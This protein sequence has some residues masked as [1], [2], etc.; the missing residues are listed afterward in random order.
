MR[1]KL[2]LILLFIISFAASA[3]WYDFIGNLQFDPATP[4]PPH[5]E[6]MMFYDNGAHAV[7]Y[8]NDEPD[9]TLNVGQ[10]NFI[11]VRNVTGSTITDGSAVIVSGSTG[12]TPQIS[13]A[14]ADLIETTLIIGLA[15]HSIENNSFGY[16]TTEGIVRGLDTSSFVDGAQL[17]LSD[18]TAGDLTNLPP[19]PPMIITTIGIVTRAHATQGSVFVRTITIVRSAAV[20]KNKIRNGLGD[21]QFA[22]SVLGLFTT[23]NNASFDNGGTIAGTLATTVVGAEQVEGTRTYKYTQASGS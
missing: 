11:R 21:A 12:T 23:G 13:L 19:R 4:N 16:V 10:E 20:A 7:S 14:Q 3:Q 22:S 2:A 1:K 5:T 6:G 8:Y 9:V 17:F 18:T 15:T